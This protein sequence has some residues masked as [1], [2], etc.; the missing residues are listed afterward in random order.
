ME[1]SAYVPLE[2]ILPCISFNSYLLSF[3][4]NDYKKSLIKHNLHYGSILSHTI[5]MVDC[6][7]D[8]SIFFFVFFYIYK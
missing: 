5:Q 7:I 1:A 3:Y 2:S 6:N 8:L 4:L